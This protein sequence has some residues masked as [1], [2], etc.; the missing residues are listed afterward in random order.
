[1]VYFNQLVDTDFVAEADLTVPADARRQAQADERVAHA[2]QVSGDLY[3][4]QSAIVDA[5]DVLDLL[6]EALY[7]DASGGLIQTYRLHRQQLSSAEAAGLLLR[8]RLIETEVAYLE[9]NLPPGGRSDLRALQT[10]IDAA[11]DAAGSVSSARQ[12]VLDR[13]E[14]FNLQAQAVETR[15]Y[16]LELAIKD[17]QGRL[18]GVEEYLVEARARGERTRDQELEARGQID[19]ER[20]DLEGMLTVLHELRK[21]LEP[22]VLTGRLGADTV[23][24][25]E[26]RSD[27]RN[28]LASTEIRLASMRSSVSSGGDFFRRLDA[29]R[30]RL[31]DLERLA[32]Q[33]REL[34]DRAETLEVDD[35]KD[36][37]RFQ[38]RIVGELDREGVSIA[39]SNEGVSGRIG[40]RAFIN[41]A[42]FFEDMLTRADMG[43]AD[44]YWYRKET[45]SKARQELTREKVRRLRA[46]EEAFR[47]VLGDR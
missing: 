29:S 27:A 40:E 1:M 30:S 12:F 16:H 2:V 42:A 10:E 46:L 37:V 23:A 39:R 34:M 8:S 22:R 35:I 38:R 47:S 19:G 33:A 45:T 21:K 7:Q 14:V 36:E 24:E 13:R 20:V 9:S 41:V 25:S 18:T 4:Q 44:V 28:R 5:T 43:V 11:T 31:L 15:I 17:L 6:E 26:Y 3:R 32:S